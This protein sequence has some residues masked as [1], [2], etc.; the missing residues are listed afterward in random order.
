VQ[1]QPRALQSADHPVPTHQGE[2][3]RAARPAAQ[4][5]RQHGPS[6]VRRRRDHPG[7]VALLGKIVPDHAMM[8]G[9]EVAHDFAKLGR[10][11]MRLNARKVFYE[12]NSHTTLLLAFEDV[13]ERPVLI[14]PES[15]C[16]VWWR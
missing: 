12:G 8:E 4:A 2:A 11:T 1:P 16:P 5:L 15:D 14:R 10:R 9:Y 7:P 6:A 13:T 3:A